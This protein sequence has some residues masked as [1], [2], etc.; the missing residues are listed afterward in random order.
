[1]PSWLDLSIAFFIALLTTIA[2]TPLVMKLAIKMG[3][4]DQPNNRKVHKKLMPR[5]G[6]LAFV[7]GFFAGYLYL[8]Q[9][10][11][12]P[13]RIV[14][15]AMIIII[16]GILDDKYTLSAK[17]KFIAQ[18]AAAL[19]VVSTGLTIDFVA[20]PFI[21]KIEFGIASYAVT[22]FWIVGVTN[23]I[24]LIDGLDGLAAGVSTIALTSIFTVA[25][26]NNNIFVAGIAIILIGGTLGFLIF[27]FHPAKIFMGD[28]GALFLGYMI[29]VL[30]VIGFFKSV[31]IFSFVLPVL[32]LAVPIF[33]TF[34]AIIRRIKN[35]QQISAPDK[36]HLHHNLLA[37]GFG[38]R[39]TVL[40]IYLMSLLFGLSAVVFTSSIVWGTLFIVGIILFAMQFTSEVLGWL[41]EKPTPIL[42]TIKKLLALI[43]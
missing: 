18:I 9:F 37:L 3:V 23:A 30:S 21:G 32:I 1:M 6:G 5:L 16:V 36:F 24:N 34:F 38:H 8:S 29:A 12:T 40:I 7:I 13:L 33:D 4:V 43:Q 42:S 20:L 39:G 11:D 10:L 22:V 31:A 19:L 25:V 2:V 27:N 15:G 26:L 17:V 41:K 35:K 28:T 14:L